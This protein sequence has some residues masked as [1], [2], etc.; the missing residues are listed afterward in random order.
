MSRH[1]GCRS[2]H[3]DPEL[4][5]TTLAKTAVILKVP[6]VHR[7]IIAPRYLDIMESMKRILIVPG[8]GNEMLQSRLKWLV[9]Q[10]QSEGVKVDVFDAHWSSAETYI[11]KM[12]RL[13]KWIFEQGLMPAD[14]VSL[15]GIS[16][17]G[18]LALSLFAAQPST[19]DRLLLIAAKLKRPQLIGPH[20]RSQHP[21]L[22]AAVEASQSAISTLGPH[23]KKKVVTYRP[24]L[25]FVV[26]TKDMVVDGARAKIIPAFGHGFS[27]VLSLLFQVR[28]SGHEQLTS[29]VD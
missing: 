11:H 21:A 15:Y 2:R 22:V 24:L 27:I 20:Y 25:D 7:R 4:L 13:E 1:G 14:K 9:G 23:D 16:A 10:W 26:S 29:A 19:F 6:S 28:P 12:R 17:G 8:L 3:I 5:H 18:S